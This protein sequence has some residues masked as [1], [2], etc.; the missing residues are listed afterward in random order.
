VI[1]RQGQLLRHVV[2]FSEV[3]AP[4]LERL[5]TSALQSSQ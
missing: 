5:I 4:E 2:G 3:R 1:N